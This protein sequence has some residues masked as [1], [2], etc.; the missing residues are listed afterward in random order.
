VTGRP[1]FGELLGA[2]RRHLT[3]QPGLPPPGRGD[4]EE[5]SR[6]LLRVV[7]LLSRYLHDTATAVSAQPASAPAPADPWG[8]ARGQGR[9]ALCNA[10]GFLLRPG[11]PRPA[12][13]AA[14]SANPVQRPPLV[15]CLNLT[16]PVAEVAEDAQRLLQVLG[17]PAAGRW[18]GPGPGR[19]SRRPA[20]AWAWEGHAH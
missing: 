10:A 17:N 2:A 8:R 5:V 19:G 9:D 6:S 15:E 4:V 18:P 16:T 20:R 13:P 3:G 14:P 7:I 1:A 12:W 11:T